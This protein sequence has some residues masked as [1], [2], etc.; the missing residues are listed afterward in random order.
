M[1]EIQKI[2]VTTVRTSP[3]RLIALQTS[4]TRLSTASA[5]ETQMTHRSQFT[6]IPP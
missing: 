4:A 6:K 5:P 2:H 1:N 3:V